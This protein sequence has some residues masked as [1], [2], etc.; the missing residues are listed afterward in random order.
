MQHI[1]LA[2]GAVFSVLA[3]VACSKG[4]QLNLEIPRAATPPAAPM[5]GAPNVTTT[6]GGKSLVVEQGKTKTTGYHGWV[7]FN[8]VEGKTLQGGGTTMRMDKS[9]V[10]LY[11]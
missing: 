2:L 6:L 9:P 10:N 8:V 3:L 4:G 7:S 5:T 11:Q 1:R